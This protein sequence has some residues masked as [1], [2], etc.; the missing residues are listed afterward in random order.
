MRSYEM[1]FVCVECI[2]DAHQLP[3]PRVAQYSPY[4]LFPATLTLDTDFL[5]ALG[6]DL[7]EPE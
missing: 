6:D 1:W 4:G 5:T 2:I 7:P 3:T